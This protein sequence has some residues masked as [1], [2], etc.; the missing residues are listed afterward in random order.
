MTIK[1]WRFKFRNYKIWTR[2]YKFS[3]K[4]PNFKIQNCL[5]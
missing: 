2:S 3:F 5:I 1:N 4:R